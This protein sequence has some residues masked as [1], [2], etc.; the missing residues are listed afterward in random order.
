VALPLALA[1]ALLPLGIEAALAWWADLRGVPIYL[2]LS[3]VQVV[4]VVLIYRRL[5]RWQGRML[6]D[7]EQ[8]ILE[9]VTVRA[10]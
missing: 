7:R 6:E 10:E 5:L 8:R 3:L 4:L 1:P 9:A 2:L